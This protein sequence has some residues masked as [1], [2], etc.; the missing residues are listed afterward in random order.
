MWALRVFKLQL[1]CYWTLLES[2]LEVHGT[3]SAKVQLSFKQREAQQEASLEMDIEDALIKLDEQKI[4][5]VSMS[6]FIVDNNFR[7]KHGMAQTLVAEYIEEL[8]KKEALFGGDW[9]VTME[10]APGKIRNS[11]CLIRVLS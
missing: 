11:K 2:S 9:A 10:K 7:Q 8:A 4:T 5:I 6:D 1:S 3:N